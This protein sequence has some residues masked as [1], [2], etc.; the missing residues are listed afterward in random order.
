MKDLACSETGSSMDSKILALAFCWA[1]V[2]V[3]SAQKEE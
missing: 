3:V 2:V 1:M